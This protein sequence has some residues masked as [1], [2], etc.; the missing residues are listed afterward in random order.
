MWP[1]WVCY[2]AVDFRRNS[3]NHLCSGE[4]GREVFYYWP[5]PKC[6]SWLDSNLVLRLKEMIKSSLS[7]PNN[8]ESFMTYFSKERK[9][10]KLSI[11]KSIVLFLKKKKALKYVLKYFMRSH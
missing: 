9:E 2:F 6:S 4:V 7:Y 8:Y 1:P 10:K 3:G 11:W 5:T